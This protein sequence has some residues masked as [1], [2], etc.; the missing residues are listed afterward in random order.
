MIFGIEIETSSIKIAQVGKKYELL[1][2]EII[3]VPEG[4]LSTEGV[5]DIDALVKNISK[6]L[7]KFEVKNP[8]V[9]FA[10]SGPTDT[11]VRILKLPY[12]GRDE[13]ETN[14][15]FELD[16]YIPFNVK[17]VYYDFHILNQ[18]KEKG[19]SEILVAVATKKIIDEYTTIFEKAGMSPVLVD[20]SALA[21]YNL[22]ELNY[23]DHHAV[24]VINIGENFINFAIA[25]KNMPL[26]IR[27][28]T[29][30]FDMKMFKDNENEIRNFAD[31]VASEIYR[32]IEY[33]KSFM[34]EENVK[35]IYITGY[36]TIYPVFISS[37]Q[38]RLDQEIL[39]FDPFRKIKINKKIEAKMQKYAHLSA[40]SIGLSLRG[41]E[42]IK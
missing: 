40:V 11:A 23:L 21:L 38:E 16:K 24:V 19:F 41:T 10:V 13:I 5:L 28:S 29:N 6:I 22:Y 15:P 2:W 26:Y 37:L 30:A 18:S 14:L 31:E 20:I 33:F 39:L 34:A 25:K 27:D 35:K 4:V 9:A 32:Q 17:E 3:D 42:K 36:P 8:Q 1:N 7:V 12:I